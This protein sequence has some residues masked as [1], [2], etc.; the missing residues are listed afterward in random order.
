MSRRPVSRDCLPVAGDDDASVR[1]HSD[2]RRYEA[3]RQPD[4][5]ARA[6]AHVRAPV[7]Q[8]AQ[9][10]AHHPVGTG[11]ANDDPAVLRNDRPRRGRVR[12]EGQFPAVAEAR[13]E[14][15]GRGV[16]REGCGTPG[17]GQYLAVRLQREGLRTTTAL[18]GAADFAC[19]EA[20]VDAAVAEALLQ[21]AVL[22]EKDDPSV[23]AHRDPLDPGRVV[24]PA[25]LQPAAV[26]EASIRTSSRRRQ[27]DH[28][29]D[30]DRRQ[31]PRPRP[32][33]S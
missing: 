1:L 3:V 26:P 31:Q 30:D 24:V 23:G 19:A 5:A 18:V 17:L 6:E 27:R 12:V 15:P 14:A 10:P 13:V 11:D 4:R 25:R 9:E 20:L 21:P 8:E 33:E 32:P 7:R 2:G 22:S 29:R 28:Q 16:P